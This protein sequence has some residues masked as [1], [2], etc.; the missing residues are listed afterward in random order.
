MPSDGT[1]PT[2]TATDEIGWLYPEDIV[3]LPSSSNRMGFGPSPGLPNKCSMV[4]SY[5]QWLGYR[6]GRG[7]NVD[8]DSTSHQHDAL[9][10]DMP[11]TWITAIIPGKP[12]ALSYAWHN[13]MSSYGS[14]VSAAIHMYGSTSS[15]AA[16]W[17]APSATEGFSSK[18]LVPGLGPA[19]L[20][21]TDC[22]ATRS[23][24][25]CL[26]SRLSMQCSSVLS[27]QPLGS[28]S[29]AQ[30]PIVYHLGATPIDTS[31]PT[32]AKQLGMPGNE[33]QQAESARKQSLLLAPE[34]TK[35]Q[36]H[37]NSIPPSHAGDQGRLPVRPKCR[38]RQPSD[39][40]RRS[41]GASIED[42]KIRK[43]ITKS[44]PKTI[45]GHQD[46]ALA[47]REAAPIHNSRLNRR[48]TAIKKAVRDRGAC[49]LRKHYRKKV[50][51]FQDVLAATRLTCWY[52]SVIDHRPAQHA[53]AA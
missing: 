34:P 11:S 29:A 51:Q 3:G 7:G 4:D 50:W 41:S 52:R 25:M 13:D 20:N 32:F 42:A 40:T 46:F 28:G 16:T 33:F 6:S 44:C 48:L 15:P 38:S 27:P 9:L 23:Q 12:P 35:P 47:L 24:D 43:R 18:S 5:G 49:V 19:Q 21:I 31:L 10:A 8:F 17:L 1:A 26:S 2:T 39:R 22:A 36:D 30:M 14:G 37:P 53:T 45:P